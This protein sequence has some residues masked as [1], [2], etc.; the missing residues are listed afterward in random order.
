MRAPGFW[1]ADGVLP[2]LLA[3]LGA[4][5]GTVAAKR[6]SREG[7]RARLPAIIVG[8]LTAGGDGKT[9]AAM[10]LA[11]ILVA[12]GERPAFLTRGYGRAQE[13]GKS[14]AV[15]PARHGVNEAGDEALLLARHGLTIAGADR[16]ESAELARALGATVLILDDGFQSRRLSAHLSLLVIDAHYGA[17]NGRCIPAGPL[18]APLA[19]QLAAADALAVIGDG[20]PGRELAKGRARKVFDA[21]I[22]PDEETAGRLRGARVAAFAGVGRP[23]KFFRTLRETGVE[24][25]A[26]RAFPDHHRFSADDL[27]GL[28][29][30]RQSTDALLV[31]TEKDAMRLHGSALPFV[32]LPIRVVFAAADAVA[33]TLAEA[34]A[35][36]RLRAS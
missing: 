17:G 20:A 36:A 16:A 22:I 34:V 10:A 13:R 1:R 18:R 25:V 28:A 26:T 30:L 15:D 19:A 5:Y 6:L 11:E 32:A 29:A 27:A 31:T 2:R 8:G 4:A 7:P 12:N 35:C 24:I 14:F 9:P 33:E 21:S 23:E 3:P